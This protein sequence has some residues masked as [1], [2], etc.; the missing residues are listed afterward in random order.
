MNFYISEHAK[1]RAK[2]TRTKEEAVY[3]YNRNFLNLVSSYILYESNPIDPV[4]DVDVEVE[5]P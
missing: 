3:D 1:G 5:S 2:D 4:G